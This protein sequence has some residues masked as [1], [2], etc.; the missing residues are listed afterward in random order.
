M[1][2]S[3]K[4]F[5][6]FI[7]NFIKIFTLFLTVWAVVEN[8]YTFRIRR[9]KVGIGFRAVHIGD[10]HGR[11]KSP[12]A[13]KI[14]PAVRKCKPD[15]IFLTGDIVSRTER[16]FTGLTGFL[17]SLSSVA[18]VY[19]VFGNH[20]Q[21]LPEDKIKELVKI[22]K[23]S[24]V[25]LLRNESISVRVG[26]SGAEI[27]VAG[28]EARREIYK[29]D[30]GYKNLDTLS[31]ADAEELLGKR[32]GGRVFLLSHNPMTAP[33]FARWGADF[34]LSGHVHGGVVRIFG[35]GL[36]SPERKFFPKYTKGL[37]RVCRKKLLVTSGV[38]KL[39][40]FNPPEIVLYT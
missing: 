27:T 21:D 36:L 34:I 8:F 22:Y 24:G 14:L 33:A 13:K 19:A 39:R 12:R 29:K 17:G 1:K 30:G 2:K 20:E 35:V 3:I 18:P 25:R 31:L 32:R 37:Y 15:I 11:L 7:K 23:K 6:I 38:G 10:V 16:D 4:I 28:A 9:E 5:I 40:L 26:N